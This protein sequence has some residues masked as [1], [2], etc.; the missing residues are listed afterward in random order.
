MMFVQL[1][2]QRT[3]SH[4][5]IQKN[6][7]GEG[8][9]LGMGRLCRLLRHGRFGCGKCLVSIAIV[10]VCTPSADIDMLALIAPVPDASEVNHLDFRIS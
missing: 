6:V 10:V 8:R 4:Q 2:H 7:N 3:D 9:F 1:R 5:L